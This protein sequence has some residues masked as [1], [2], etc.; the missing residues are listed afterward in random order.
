MSSTIFPHTVN[1]ADAD[2]NLIPIGTILL[3]F[4]SRNI[5]TKTYKNT[6]IIVGNSKRK[7]KDFIQ[8]YSYS[9][10][11]ILRFYKNQLTTTVPNI[12]L[13][14]IS[15]TVMEG[16]GDYLAVNS[17]GNVVNVHRK[18]YQV[19][20]LS[21][22]ID[23]IAANKYALTYFFNGVVGEWR[24][25]PEASALGR[26]DDVT[27]AVV[28]YGVFVSYFAPINAGGFG[29]SYRILPISISWDKAPVL[30][31]NLNC[32]GHVVN[33]LTYLCQNLEAE[34]PNSSLVVD[35]VKNSESNIVC[36]NSV[37]V[38]NIQLLIS[39]NHLK[40]FTLNI[41]NFVGLISFKADADIMM[42]NGYLPKSTKSNNTYTLLIYRD[43]A[44]LKINILHKNR[45][46]AAFTN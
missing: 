19:K 20:E 25:A 22:V 15:G 9:D 1:E 27:F 23:S 30:G 3:G 12:Y 14:D 13:K 34:E 44:K 4:G 6:I 28:P 35:T 16:V 40:F 18:E 17:L 42:E 37:K 32:D 7:L 21:D 46:M 33:N 2:Y 8:Y 5:T 41:I 11:A 29:N 26:F 39:S 24:Y 38:L 31:S 43:D 10:G 36:G 45:N